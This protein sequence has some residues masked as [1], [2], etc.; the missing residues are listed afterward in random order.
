MLWE[1]N[2][3]AN[4]IV[5]VSDLHF[6]RDDSFAQ[7]VKNKTRF[8]RFVDDL[9]AAGDVAELVI[10]GDFLD[11]WIVPLSVPACDDSSEHYRICLANNEIVVDALN[12][13]MDAGLK[14]TY[15][16]GNHD[17]TLEADVLREAMPQLNQACDARGVGTYITGV[18]NEIAIEH[19]HRYEV[20][21]APDTVSNRDLVGNDDSLLPPGYFYA[22]LGT[23][24]MAEGRP[25]VKVDYPLIDQA[26]QEDDEDQMGAYLH[27]Q[28]MTSLLLSRFT[29]RVGFD[30]KIFD[31]RIAGFHDVYSEADICPRLEEDGRISAPVLYRDFQR[32]WDERQRINNVPVPIG[33]REAA[34]GASEI[35]FF[36][37]QA[38]VQHLDRPES[39][40]DVVVFGHTHVPDFHDFGN[41][42]YYLND[43][44]W[45]DDNLDGD[46]TCTFA[47]IESGEVDTARV[48]VYNEDG[49]VADITERS[50]DAME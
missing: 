38:S 17:M 43:G 3:N 35:P 5:I 18:R 16:I 31:M 23:Q 37:R 24:W 4:K 11:E 42:R 26:P 2:G 40:I 29:P 27:Y 46:Y 45:I 14:V 50:T 25:V 21:S 22:R 32:T 6:G 19:G 28:V 9:V 36:K 10:A 34:R 41:G 1:K 12:R 33:F 48:C 7:N 39:G 47:L 49:S 30:E 20:Y 8:S 44:T 13:A 15:V